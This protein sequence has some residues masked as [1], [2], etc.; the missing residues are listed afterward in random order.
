MGEPKDSPFEQT[1]HLLDEED[2]QTLAAIDRG[3]KAAEDG[4]L[5]S[6]EEA[7]ERMEKWLTESSTRK[8]R[9]KIFRP[10]WT[11]F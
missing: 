6:A 4:R 8:M 11:T 1:D 7:R 5:V 2:E 3:L 9:Y 10:S